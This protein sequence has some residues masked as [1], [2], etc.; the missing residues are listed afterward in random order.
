MENI[1]YLQKINFALE[2]LLKNP[3]FSYI[4]SI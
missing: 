1:Y 2:L 3:T 4:M